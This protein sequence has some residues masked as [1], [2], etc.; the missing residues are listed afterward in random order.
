M[1]IIKGEYNEAK[2]YTDV[3]EEMALSQIKTLCV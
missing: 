1:K 3:V 2:V